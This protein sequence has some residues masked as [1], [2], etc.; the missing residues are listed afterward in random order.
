M[1]DPVDKNV[2]KTYQ[3]MDQLRPNPH[4]NLPGQGDEKVN[5]AYQE[6]GELSQPSTYDC[7]R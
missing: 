7:I 5:S 4:I 2:N 3:E 6:L 1:N